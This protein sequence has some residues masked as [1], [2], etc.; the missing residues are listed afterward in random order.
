M[1]V[2]EFGGHSNILT[3]KF[4]IADVWKLEKSLSIISLRPYNAGS[5]NEVSFCITGCL[6]KSNKVGLSIFF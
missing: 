6:A 5:T 3:P 1:V 4:K 2:L